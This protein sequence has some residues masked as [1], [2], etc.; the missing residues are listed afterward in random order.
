MAARKKVTKTE[1]KPGRKPKPK[2]KL[3]N[4]RVQVLLTLAEK[5]DVTALRGE[6]DESPWCA[7]AIRQ[8]IRRERK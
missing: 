6:Q 8:R 1:S 2:D 3:H 4:A 5:A 7:E